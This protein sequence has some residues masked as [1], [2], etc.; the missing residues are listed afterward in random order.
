MIKRIQCQFCGRDLATV[1]QSTTITM[2]CPVCGQR[3]HSIITNE[4]EIITRDY[5]PKRMSKALKK[6]RDNIL[7]DSLLL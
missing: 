4:N 7:R 6:K 1:D 2:E 3:I 5:A